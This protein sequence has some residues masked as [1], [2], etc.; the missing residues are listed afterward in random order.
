M[1]PA[2]TRILGV[3]TS[4]RS[5]GVAV[6]EATGHSLR[7]VE[8]SRI[9]SPQ[10]LSLSAALERLQSGVLDVIE[11]LS[12]DISA[13][14]GIFHCRN[15]KTAVRLGEARGVVIAACCHNGLPVFEY[16]P[17]RVKQAVVGTG[18]ASKD[19][20]RRMVMSMLGLQDEP[21]DDESD[22]LAIAICHWNCRTTYAAIAPEP[23]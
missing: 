1:S 21:P 8:H 22:A 18:A 5:S 3:D 17:R 9:R 14:E 13:I 23:I 2:T 6:I 12:P 15:V 20:V 10:T 7:A 4:L 16:A 19:Q 11:R